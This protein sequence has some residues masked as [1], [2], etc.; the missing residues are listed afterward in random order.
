MAA[1]RSGRTTE[2][3]SAKT[4]VLGFRREIITDVADLP[5]TQLNVPALA[6]PGNTGT[7]G[8]FPLWAWGV[9]PAAWASD[10][11]GRARAMAPGLCR[12]WLLSAGLTAWPLWLW[13][14]R[15]HA[16]WLARSLAG[17]PSSL[18]ARCC[19]GCYEVK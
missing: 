8:T 13:L 10:W 18:L 4:S 12:C 15:T 11:L 1:V 17:C 9:L 14:C 16:R 3:E 5:P 2:S 19:F 6:A 7:C